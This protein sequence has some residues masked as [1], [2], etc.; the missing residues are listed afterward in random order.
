MRAID[1]EDESFCLI[2]G[3]PLSFSQQILN[4]DPVCLNC[5]TRMRLLQKRMVVDGIEWYVGYEYNEF[6]ERILFRWK[7]GCDI[8]LC[9]ALASPI[10][11]WLVSLCQG[12]TCCIC[13]SGQAQR[14]H[15]GFE[16]MAEMMKAL[17]IPIYSPLYKRTDYKQS[18]QSAT[19]RQEIAAVLKK[20]KVYP[21]LEEP[22]MWMDDVC[23]TG[24]TLSASLQ[25][26]PGSRIFVLAGHP[27]WL[28]NMDK[29]KS[30]G[31]QIKDVLIKYKA[32][33][34]EQNER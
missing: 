19:H 12:Y 17:S 8:A 26:I 28:E 14:Q 18:S 9:Q 7:E 34:G 22:V 13:P 33:R 32:K 24:S 11:E 2:C 16:A 29:R 20:K 23:T 6:L 21:I 5:Q 31:S 25:L 27:L 4:S 3:E 10:R 30:N 1:S 15:R